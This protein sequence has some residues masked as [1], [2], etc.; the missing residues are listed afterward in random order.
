MQIGQELH[1]FLCLNLSLCLLKIKKVINFQKEHYEHKAESTTFLAE[2]Y[3][4]LLQFA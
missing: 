1:Y 3:S 2:L 4:V